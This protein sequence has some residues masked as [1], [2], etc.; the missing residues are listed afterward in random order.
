[1][2][3]RAQ[4]HG[5]MPCTYRGGAGVWLEGARPTKA[6]GISH[7]EKFPPGLTTRDQPEVNWL[8]LSYRPQCLV[9][10]QHS[11][12]KCPP[13]LGCAL[14][15][16]LW[17]EIASTFSLS[18]LS[19]CWRCLGFSKSIGILCKKLPNTATKAYPDTRL[20]YW[21]KNYKIVEVKPFHLGEF[22]MQYLEP[23]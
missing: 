2:H 10:P 5:W 21:D 18:Q 13:T 15:A 6:A 7:R 11:T 9:L 23:W 22:P 20:N 16:Q 8:S 3:Y 14:N 1:M 17:R 4:P 12:H 19:H